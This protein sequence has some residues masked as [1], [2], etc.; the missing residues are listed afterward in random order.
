MNHPKIV[1]ISTLSSPLS[2][3]RFHRR[4]RFQ[5][6]P[7]VTAPTEPAH[8]LVNLQIEAPLFLLAPGALLVQLR[9]SNGRQS[10]FSPNLKFGA[11]ADGITK[12][13]SLGE[14]NHL[15]FR[16]KARG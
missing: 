16:G 10:G 11:A 9:D 1:T 13:N 5:T 12:F 2:P 6:W 7:P 4:Q 8:A 3:V 14:L 15:Q